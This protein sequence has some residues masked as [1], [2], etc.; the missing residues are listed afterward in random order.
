[1]RKRRSDSPWNKLTSDQRKQMD[2]WYFEENLGYPVILER[3]KKE[4]GIE[5]SKQTLTDYFRYR[6][7]LMNLPDG[8]GDP[9]A[10]EEEP[11]AIRVGA[12]METRDLEARTVR[13]A[14]MAAHEMAMGEPETMPVREIRAL[15]KMVSD[16]RRM[17]LE[18]KRREDK[19]ELESL[20]MILK[21]NK[22]QSKMHKEADFR[23]MVS[24][25]RKRMFGARKRS[26]DNQAEFDAQRTARAAAEPNVGVDGAGES[27]ADAKAADEGTIQQGSSPGVASVSK[28]KQA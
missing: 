1:M 14:A 18:C 10:R 19:T 7:R 2:D 22:E 28:D 6:E 26:E 25:F 17:L 8:A 5:A 21:L 23:E 15:M 13:Y 9:E 4:F 20:L 16:H 24:D 12:G 11:P 27:G 3:A